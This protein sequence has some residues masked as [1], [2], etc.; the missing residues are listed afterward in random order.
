MLRYVHRYFVLTFIIDVGLQL[1]VRHAR[2]YV[3][4]ADAYQLLA[5]N[6]AKLNQHLISL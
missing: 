1:S 4:I 5:Q 3:M 6:T 2:W